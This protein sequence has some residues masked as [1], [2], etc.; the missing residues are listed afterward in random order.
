MK[1]YHCLHRCMLSALFLLLLTPALALAQQG[2]WDQINQEQNRPE[3]WQQ[4]VENSAFPLGEA[5]AL[6]T[7]PNGA[8]LWN[9]AFGAYP[10]LDGSTVCVPMAMEF[11]RQHLGLSEIGRASCRERVLMVV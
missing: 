10:R 8:S 2:S 6:E 3:G 7:Q 9:V 1:K 4:I 5:T 11:A